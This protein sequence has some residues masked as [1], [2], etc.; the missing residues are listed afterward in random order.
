VYTTQPVIKSGCVL[1]RANVGVLER[2]KLVT[3]HE[4]ST[5]RTE[6]S[7]QHIEQP[8]FFQGDYDLYTSWQ[9]PSELLTLL[10]RPSKDVHCCCRCQSLYFRKYSK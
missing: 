10:H 3:Q 7:H 8:G 5:P 9:A 2:E 1:R 4:V 6:A